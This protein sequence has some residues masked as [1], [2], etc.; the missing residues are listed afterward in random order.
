MQNFEFCNPVKILFGK[1]Q[2]AKIAAEVPAGAKVLVTY[3]GGSIK[4]NGVYAQVVDALKGHDVLE[5][6]GIEANPVYETLMKAVE[7]V[8]REKIDFILAVGGGSVLDGTKF[9]AAAAKFPG[10]PWDMLSKQAPSQ[11]AVPI[12][13]VLTLPATGSEMNPM[14]VISRASTREKLASAFCYPQFS[15]IDPET[16]FTL[17]PRQVSNGIVD[18]FAHVLE[19][20]MTYPASAP[21]Q[22][23]FAE[24]ILTTLI[25]EGPKTLADPRDYDSRANLCWCS[26]M[27]LNGLIAVGVPQDWTTHMIGHEITAF[28][29]L[30]H[31]QTL[32]IVFPGTLAARKEQKR[33]KLL[34]YAER[35]W[36]IATGTED[37]KIDAAISKTRAFFELVGV[38]THLKDYGVEPTVI[39]Q[40]STRFAERGTTSLGERG[41]IGPK[42]VEEI[43]AHSI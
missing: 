31:G 21:L 7:I 22:D 25:E 40:I 3:G 26:T 4:K 6:S 27:A 30:D 15:V 42:Q 14:G 24:A 5:F 28:T 16:T 17:P 10:E 43:L 38:K 20:Y 23:R 39:A 37:E 29:G 41:D 13:A 11:G 18:A 34:Q 9:I 36:G 33:G 12:G 35:V 32:A 1:G 19:Q 8:K 2:I